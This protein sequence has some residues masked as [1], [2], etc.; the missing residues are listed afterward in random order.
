MAEKYKALFLDLD[1][2]VRTT[3]NGK[4]CPN[5]PEEQEVMKNR[6]DKIHEY[7]SKGYKIVAVT[8]QG[9]IGL[10]YM[11][12]KQCRD[13]LRDLDKKLDGAFDKMYYAPAPPKAGHPLTKPNPGMIHRA[14]Q[15]LNLDLSNS[16]LI[17]DRESDKGAANNAGVKFE[18]AKDFFGD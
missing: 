6:H 5:R 11:T 7:K 2:T 4:P 10:G 8:N 17:G 1:G 13:C 9:G 3:K 18:W 14:Q 16:I 15:E 12:D